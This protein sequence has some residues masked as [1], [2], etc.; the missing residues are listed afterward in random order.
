MANTKK[1]Q[2]EIMVRDFKGEFQ[3]ELME[4]HLYWKALGQTEQATAY[5]LLLHNFT[6]IEAE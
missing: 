1:T 2:P 6:K 3:A 5:L 4:R